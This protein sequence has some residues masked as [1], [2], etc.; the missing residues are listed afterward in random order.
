VLAGG[1]VYV[2]YYGVKIVNYGW[3]GGNFYLEAGEGVTLKKVVEV[4]LGV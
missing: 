3:L 4:Y 2:D 1:Q